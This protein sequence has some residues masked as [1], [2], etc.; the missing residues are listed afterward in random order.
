ML[1]AWLAALALL[2]GAGC[3]YLASPHQA[4][5]TSPVNGR[6]LRL[7]GTAALLAALVLLLSRMGPATAVFTWTVGLM[8]LWSLPPIGLRWLRFRKE[9]IG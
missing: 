4:V 6:A 1:V 2:I 3:L 5:S 9:K 8:L 7:A